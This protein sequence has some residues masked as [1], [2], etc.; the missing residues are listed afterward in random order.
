MK[1]ALLFLASLALSPLAFAAEVPAASAADLAQRLYA[2]R[3]QAANGRAPASLHIGSTFTIGDPGLPLL[4]VFN[5]GHE[6]GF[7]MVSAQDNVH[8]F[9]AYVLSGHYDPAIEH[10]AFSDWIDNYAQQIRF[11]VQEQLPSTPAID[12]AWQEYKVKSASAPASVANIGPLL[13]TTWNQGCHYNAQTP[14]GTSACGHQWTGC[15]ATA[16]AQMMKYHAYPTNGIGNHTYTW[17]SINHF[18]DFGATTYNWSGMPNSVTSANADVAQLMYHCGV[19]LEMQYGNSASNCFFD[20]SQVLPAHFNYATTAQNWLKLFIPND[21]TYQDRIAAEH[22]SLRPTFYKGSGPNGMHFFLCDGYQGSYPYNFHFN[23]GWGGLY[24]G[25]FFCSAL[26]PGTYTF[27]SGQGAVIRVMPPSVTTGIAAQAIENFS[28]YP[29]PADE[30]VTLNF[31]DA[32]AHSVSLFDMSGRRVLERQT[33]DDAIQVPTSSLGKGVYIV[34]VKD[35]QG[36]LI[37]RKRLVVAR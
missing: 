22:D 5:F 25:Y 33:A 26:N 16:A 21:T 31:K 13:S 19:A 3:Y 8:P 11:A 4:Y 37:G 20:F 34:I 10:P 18:A 15:G 30:V 17:N 35:E 12:A 1:K 28:L 27:T 9:P 29:N 36:V 24:D 7:V 2:E 32:G 6:G 23:W 14:S